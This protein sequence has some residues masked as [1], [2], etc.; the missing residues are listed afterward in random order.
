[1]TG[2]GGGASEAA[3]Q[4]V[5]QP[6]YQQPYEQQQQMSGQCSIEIQQFLDCASHQSDITFCEEFKDVMQRC[7]MSQGPFL[8]TLNN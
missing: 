8:L 5:Q 7:K 1:M 2:G 3:P 4:E 6:A